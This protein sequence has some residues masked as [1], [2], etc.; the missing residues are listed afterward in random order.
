MNKSNARRSETNQLGK[1]FDIYTPWCW[2]STERLRCEVTLRTGKTVTLAIPL[3]AAV[4]IE[5]AGHEIKCYG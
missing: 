4:E 2:S 5:E 1:L 3:G